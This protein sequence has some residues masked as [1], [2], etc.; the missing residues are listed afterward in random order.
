M[1]AL[2]L[3]TRA[4]SKRGRRTVGIVG[5]AVLCLALVPAAGQAIAGEKPTATRASSPSGEKMGNYDARKDGYARKVLAT[6]SAQIAA[7]P[8]AGVKNL[9]K[10]LGIQGLVDVDPL[11]RTP[12]R[13][14]QLDGFLTGPSA[15]RPADIAIDYVRARADVFGLSA[16]EVAGLQ[17]RKDYTDIAGTHHLSFVQ[18]VGGVTVF[19]NGLK[20]HVAKSGRLIQV[21]GSPV[22][23]LPAGPGRPG[24]S[25]AR[26]RD[27]AVEDVFGSSKASVVRSSGANSKTEFSNGDQTQLVAFQTI[28]G[29]R[30]AW[31]T[32][33]LREGYLVVQDARDGRTLFRQDLVAKD[34][35][36]AWDSYPQ[37]PR[38]GTQRTVNFTAPGW[39][40]EQLA[41]PGRQRRA[42]VARPQRRRRG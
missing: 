22:V 42:R 12:R 17:P 33:L 13:V 41:A 31:Q 14:S 38:G 4:F 23:A 11:T 9:R 28:G 1:K 26:A 24:F 25:A 20:A 6:R 35:G 19:G 32:V 3:P 36:K 40:A 5:T 21:D 8:T 7:N 27:S 10:Q 37:A 29:M 34:S 18:S 30:L 39:A 2:H 15:R 16:D